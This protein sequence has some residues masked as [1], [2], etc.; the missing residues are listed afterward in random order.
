MCGIFGW[1]G[2]TPNDYAETL[3]RLSQL[4]KHRGPDDEGFE[5]AGDWGLGFRRLSI[6]DLSPLGHQPMRTEDDRFWLVFNGEVYNYQELRHRLEQ[7]GERFRGGSDT[8]VILRLLARDGTSAL[9]SFNGMFSLALVDTEKRT[10]LLARDRL[11]V[12]PLYYYVGNEQLRF[13]SELKGL[14]AWPDAVRTLN[15][16]ALVEYLSLNFVS[17]DNCIFQG[18]RKLPPGHYLT[19]SLD[20]PADA[21]SIRY[22][23][24][25]IQEQADDATL[26]SNQL[27][28]LLNLLTDAVSIRLRSDVPVGI[29]LSGG[30]DSGLVAA[31]AGRSTKAGPLALTA[32]FGDHAFDETALARASAQH[33]GLEHRIIAQQ[34]GSVRQIDR[35]AWFYD[36]P[37]GDASAL[38]M[39]NLCAA[40]APYATVILSGDGG[41]ETF[42]GYRRY[43]KALRYRW[44][45]NVP[46]VVQRSLQRFSTA[47]P[48]Y[49]SLRYRL[50]KSTLP[51]QGFA[52]VFDDT[53]EDPAVASIITKELRRYSTEIGQPLWERW[54]G[55]AGRNLTTRQQ[56]LDYQLYLPDDILVKADRA[57]MA[58]SIEL[59]SPFL[60]YRIVEW[61]GR[62]PR[63]ALLNATEGKLPLRQLAARLLP[64]E[65]QTGPKKHFGIPF[66]TW[67]HGAE[68][69]SFVH[70][71]LV[72]SEANALGL[73]NTYAVDRVLSEHRSGKTRNLGFLIWRLLMLDAW[74]RQYADGTTFLQGPPPDSVSSL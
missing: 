53:P 31:L 46:G 67:L 56:L 4:L 65:V 62:V 68:A 33:A 25:N 43:V 44:L 45:G 29:F 49:S 19:G 6:L 18:Y 11:G 14:L 15:P 2:K 69:Y 48:T 13:A 58:N 50:V 10:F 9:Q 24:V 21:H 20:S 61:A 72:S 30:L 57:S 41:D 60:D 51:D 66:D 52:A 8:E 63:A 36:E 71:R 3:H 22:W 35:L 27:E 39:Y 64:A 74:T 47:L 59:R 32:G 26:S 37:F 42:A 16:S 1:L 12:K 34:P 28:D 23:D 54:R 5:T 55:S 38:P 17:G 40:V 73:C 70:E 7:D